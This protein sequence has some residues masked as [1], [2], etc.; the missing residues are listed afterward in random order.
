MV[1]TCIARHEI[2]SYLLGRLTP[3]AIDE[4]AGHLEECPA[5]Q[6]TADSL[7]T[8]DDSLIARLR[9]PAPT[10]WEPGD[11]AP[12]PLLDRARRLPSVSAP[13]D[14][15]RDYLLLDEIGR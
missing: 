11:E 8:D 3:Q 1:A 6:A 9:D 15:I 4:I 2:S 12:Q 5:C 13:P 14:R 7:D 10:T